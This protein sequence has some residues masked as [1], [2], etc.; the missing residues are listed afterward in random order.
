MI[1][2]AVVVGYFVSKP[3]TYSQATLVLGFVSGFAI[4]AFSMVVNDYYD[5]EVKPGEKEGDLLATVWHNGVKVHED[6]AIKGSANK[7]ARIELQNHGNPVVYR[8]ICFIP[9]ATAGAT[10]D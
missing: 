5:V 4:C 10:K 6:Y 2:L 7:P 3:S 1:G 8:N 9:E